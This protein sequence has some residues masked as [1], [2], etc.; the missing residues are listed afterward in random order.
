MISTKMIA[1]GILCWM[2]QVRRTSVCIRLSGVTGGSLV[3][4]TLVPW[5]S[6]ALAVAEAAPSLEPAL[7]EFLGV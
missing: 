7:A 2:G 4:Q 3:A 6:V 5:D 1:K